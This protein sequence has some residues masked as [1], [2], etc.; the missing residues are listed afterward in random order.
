MA[1]TQYPSR[2]RQM[3]STFYGL[4]KGKRI[5]DG[6][7]NDMLNMTCDDYPVAGT[8]E[9]R[10]FLTKGASEDDPLINGAITSVVKNYIP[11]LGESIVTAMKAGN[12][13]HVNASGD[14]DDI[15]VNFSGDD[16]T[17]LNFGKNTFVYPAMKYIEWNANKTASVKD[18]AVFVE[19]FD[20]VMT[21]AAAVDLDINTDTEKP[22]DPDNGD[23]WYDE[24]VN[25]L[26]KYSA[27][28]EEWI[29]FA[30]S[31]IKLKPTQDN[32]DTF[33]A[34]VAKLKEGQAIRIKGASHETI[35]ASYIVYK[36]S[37]PIMPAASSYILVNGFARHHQM[38]S[39]T[40]AIIERRSP[41][42]DFAV[43]CRNR[44]WGCR[45]GIND[46]DEFVNEIYGSALGDPLDYF[47][48]EGTA[49]DSFTASV[50]TGGKWSGI[51][52]IDDYV[53]FFKED[54]YY[55]LSG[56]EPPFR[57]RE[58]QAEGVQLGSHKS[59]CS[60]GGYLYYKS[61]HGIMRMSTDS[62]PVCISEELG[63][64][65]YYK[66]IAGTD[67]RKYFLQVNDKLAD[68]MLPYKRDL[69]V[70]DTR[71]G[72]WTR[73]NEL[74][75]ELAGIVRDEN[76]VLALGYHTETRE[77]QPEDIE[78][79][80]YLLDGA[81]LGNIGV[82]ALGT[83]SAAGV[84]MAVD[85]EPDFTWH[86][87]TGLLGL[88]DPDEKIARTIQIRAKTALGARLRCEISY[89][90]SNEWTQ[91]YNEIR[92]A[93]T[94]H[95]ISHKPGVRCDTFRLRFSGVGACDIYSITIT[96]EGAGD[97]VHYGYT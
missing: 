67:G 16:Q 3:I 58:V 48:Y 61:N 21:D 14:N 85:E 33:K 17:L 77:I 10:M 19:G 80:V 65:E 24:S 51:G 41:M 60:I 25:G 36:L 50:G 7:W 75:F 74:S 44:I 27:A 13:V 71:N 11:G 92:E 12:T 20:F 29:A 83:V 59:V 91:I 93:T 52:V 38:E 49:A 45:Y 94:T 46:D 73:E 55:V 47:N 4:D 57:L 15:D 86:A 42:F 78:V 1:Y 88:G 72:L 70:Y 53:V 64:D 5:R 34:F 23:I 63:K 95:V 40:H 56:T 39:L 28:T 96:T 79:T 69:F 54:R 62:L 2:D 90:D 68:I 76:E 9:K 84:I 30:A 43:E 87:E 18:T 6:A 66:A 97:N 26:Y 81:Y 31:Y 89:N 37:S 82:D 22:I 35:N 8:R 32:A